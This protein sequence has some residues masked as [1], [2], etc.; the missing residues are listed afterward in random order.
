M[1]KLKFYINN[2]TELNEYE[3]KNKLCK[4]NKIFIYRYDFM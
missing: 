2:E 4:I 1:S 3:V